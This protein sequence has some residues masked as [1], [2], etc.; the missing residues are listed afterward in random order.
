[1]ARE[2]VR[3]PVPAPV[4]F[5]KSSCITGGAGSR[6]HERSSYASDEKEMSLGTPP[7]AVHS[8]QW[9]CIFGS[10]GDVG[11]RPGVC[12]LDLECVSSML[13]ENL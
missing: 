8:L 12:L 2:K 13:V 1:M 9:K 7:G 11:S 5:R 10:V 6:I 4:S 3:E